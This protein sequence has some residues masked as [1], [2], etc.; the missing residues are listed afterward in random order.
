MATTMT[1]KTK[2]FGSPAFV[3][4]WTVLVRKG[5]QESLQRWS[6]TRNRS[7]PSRK[8]GT[9]VNHLRLLATFEQATA[10]ASAIRQGNNSKVMSAS[11]LE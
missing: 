3:L 5:Q 11:A 8:L 7:V 2:Q 4:I 9:C 1:V 6:R 10:A